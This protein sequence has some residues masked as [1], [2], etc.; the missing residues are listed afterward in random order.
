MQIGGCG[1]DGTE[2][3]PGRCPAEGRLRV[4]LVSVPLVGIAP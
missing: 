1:L 3:V 2:S 4:R